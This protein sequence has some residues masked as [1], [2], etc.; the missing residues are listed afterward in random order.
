MLGILLGPIMFSVTIALL[1]T[2]A[3]L[4]ITFPLA[5]PFAWLLFVC[6]RGFGRFERS[7]LDALLGVSIADPH[8]PLPEGSWIRRILARV[9]S[10]SRWREIAYFL[11]ALPIGALQFAVATAL[12]CGTLAL[13]A[14]P[15]YVGSLPG[16]TA[17][18]GLFDISSGAGAFAMCVVGLVSLGVLAPWVTLAMADVD[19]V[20]ARKLIGPSR[21]TLLARQ[22]RQVE[23]RRVAA[24][25]SAEAERRRIER[26]LHDG[27]QQRL[28]ALAMD[29]GRAREHFEHDPAQA[30]Q[31]VAEAHEEAKAALVELRDLV[32]GFNPAILQDRGLDA[33]LSA[34]VARA[35]IPVGLDV[36]VTPRPAAA[37]ESTA[38]FI[39][40]EAL[41]N[42]AK[43]S[44]ATGARVTIARR[45]DRLVIDVTDNGTGGAEPSRGTG[46]RGLAERVE[47]LG[48]WMQVLSPPG[49]PTTVLVELPCAS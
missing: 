17:E 43:H 9:R 27:A 5:L 7:R 23:A 36:D 33:A 25:D 31:L 10:G 45:G 8:G 34:V 40:A 16:D 46:L 48:G 32:R 15:L 35:P 20:L 44:H 30:Q 42:V 18:F 37:V 4:A 26:D 28:V 11:L 47:A 12:W 24:V 49:G 21:D 39:V 19:A 1:A 6:V 2:S 14:L 3:G 38:Y 29:L 13:I 22:V 41:A